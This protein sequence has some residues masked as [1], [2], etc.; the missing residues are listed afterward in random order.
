MGRDRAEGG[1]TGAACT[2]LVLNRPQGNG[3]CTNAP[4]TYQHLKG[5]ISKQGKQSLERGG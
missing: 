2:R 4:E 1:G 5:F 3:A